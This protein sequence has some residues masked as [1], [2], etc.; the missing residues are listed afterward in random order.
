MK[1]LNLQLAFLYHMPREQAYYW[2]IWLIESLRP[3]C[4]NQQKTF[5][6][7]QSV[8]WQALNI[9]DDIIDG[10][11]PRAD[12]MRA[13]NNFRK[14]LKVLYTSNLPVYFIDQADNIINTW[15]KI[16]RQEWQSAKLLIKN[17][18]IKIPQH[19]PSAETYNLGYKKSLL[20]AIMPIIS[21]LKLNLI[22]SRRELKIAFNF[23]KYALAAKQLADDASDW[24]V[25]L[26]NGILNPVNLLVL[27][28]AKNKKIKLNLKTKPEIAYLLFANN[29]GPQTA[30]NILNL[31]KKAEK[32]ALKLGIKNT[33][34]LTKFLIQP[35]SKSAQKVLNFQNLL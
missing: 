5:C 23:F 16:N 20:L 10:D 21:A 14:F 30:K 3:N 1:K 31:C 18:G 33:M 17:G 6:Q 29:A 19:L 15:E 2:P 12:L 11:N 7:T 22:S 26:E 4:Q 25:D 9:Y 35:L 27:K 8:L 28:A 32:E 34:P 13:N 24:L